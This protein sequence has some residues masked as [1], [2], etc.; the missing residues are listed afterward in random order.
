[1]ISAAGRDRYLHLSCINAINVIII[2]IM[3]YYVGTSSIRYNTM[4]IHRDA[5]IDLSNMG[6]SILRKSNTYHHQD[7]VGI[8]LSSFRVRNVLYLPTYLPIQYIY[9]NCAVENVPKKKNN[10]K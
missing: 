7:R 3:L 5:L 8:Q 4:L 6:N 9:N 2:I 1:M 10:N